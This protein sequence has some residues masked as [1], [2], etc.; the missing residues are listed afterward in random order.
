MLSSNK[1]LQEKQF[2]FVMEQT[3]GHVPFGEN[4]RKYF[5]SNPELKI[6]WVLTKFPN[7]HWYERL[8]VL[9]NWSFR[10]SLKAWL[11]L[12]SLHKLKGL[13]DL[14]FFHTQVVSLIAA[15]WLSRRRPVVI[16]LD[17]TPI[18]YDRVGAA[19]G[20]RPGNFWLE[21]IKF[22]LNK[23]AFHSA[24]QLVTWSEWAKKSLI[25]DYGISEGKI[26]VIA[27]G[28]NLGFWKDEDFEKSNNALTTLRLLFVGGDFKRKGGELLLD[29]FRKLPE[30]KCE[31]HLVTKEPVEPAQGVFVYPAITPNSPQLQALFHKADIFVLP[32]VGDCLP[33]AIGEAMAAGLPVVSTD[34]GAISEAV[35]SGE[36]GFLIKPGDELELRRVLLVLLEN[37]NLRIKMSQNSLQRAELMFD[38]DKNARRLLEICE[39]LLSG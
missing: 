10:A 23:R 11:A 31:L 33:V 1:S 34:V 15:P 28:T 2:T 37:K 12:R 14:Y 16:S 17:A 13:A 7:E 19:Y 38:A 22:R 24:H 9:S 20:H 8:P 26:Q 3:L 6:N 29:V 36:N 21:Q 5:D 27:P 32:T 4:L 30:G 35:I 25:E 39:A 18:N